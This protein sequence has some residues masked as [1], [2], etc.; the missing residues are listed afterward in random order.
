MGVSVA[1]IRK[2]YCNIVLNVRNQSFDG[3][4]M[5]LELGVVEIKYKFKFKM[6]SKF[7]N[8]RLRLR[9]ISKFE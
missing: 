2:M 5:I 6:K 4:K 1:I 8:P 9:T 7:L 3:K